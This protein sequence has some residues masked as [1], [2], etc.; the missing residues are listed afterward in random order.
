MRKKEKSFDILSAFN[1]YAPGWG[2]MF[3]LLGLL[4]AGALVGNLLQMGMMKIYGIDFANT[5][6]MLVSYPVMFVIAMLYASAKSRRNMLFN[7]INIPVDS[8]RVK[9]GQMNRYLLALMCAVGTIAA[10]LAVEPA[11]KIVPTTGEFWGP[12]Y[13][14]IK[15]A[16]EGLT[17]GPLWVALLSTA[18]FAPFFEEW[19][20]RGMI[21]RGLLQKT[22]PATAIIVS[23]VFFALIHLNPWQAI[24]AFLLGCLFGL[25][26][27]KTGSLKLTM[28]MHCVNNTFSVILSQIPALEGTE[29]LGDIITDKLQYGIILCAC[30]CLTG[31]LVDRICR[32]K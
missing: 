32:L 11:I 10:A 12:F 29:Y 28:L 18:V 21:L 25:V 13:E 31:F 2:G 24:P 3:A 14:A 6:S 4:L 1:G 9:E 8:Y 15:T 16:M 7:E 27:Y 30:L 5:Y 22:S 26:Y 17:G 23:A 20:C 19:L